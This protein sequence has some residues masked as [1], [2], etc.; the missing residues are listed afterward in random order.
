MF[1]LKVLGLTEA[2]LYSWWATRTISLVSI[3]D[4][5][6]KGPNHLVIKVD[7]I[8]IPVPLGIAPSREHV[9]KILEFS[10][11]LDDSDNVIVHCHQGISRSA[12]TAIGILIHHGLSIIDAF[13]TV[14]SIREIMRPNTLLLT[15]F[16][17][18]L[19]L[20]GELYN[21]GIEWNKRQHLT[22]ERVKEYKDKEISD[23]K[24]HS[25]EMMREIIKKINN[26]GSNNV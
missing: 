11:T 19:G 21:A 15:H 10:N 3:D 24:R 12:A 6:S 7:D 1:G 9:D 22:D 4:F 13:Q 23:H 18:A 2:K 17:D 26:M 5:E 16:D 25:A 14:Y 8:T 20:N